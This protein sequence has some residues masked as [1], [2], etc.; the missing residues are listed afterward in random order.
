MV[1][2]SEMG[3][4]GGP[5]GE[6][7]SGSRP[8]GRNPTDLGNA[9]RLVARHGHN[10]RY[11]VADRE[12]RVWEGGLWRP[13]RTLEVIRLAK[14][15]VEAMHE[16]AEAAPT[17]EL[18]RELLAHGLASEASARIRAMVELAASEP[19]VVALP[20]QFDRDPW[21]LN[22]A[23]GTVDLRTGALRGHRREDL[24]TRIAPVRFDQGAEAP[25]WEA[26][27]S[28]ITEG[29]AGLVQ[30]LQRVAGYTLTGLTREHALFI[31]YGPGGNGKTTFVEALR[32]CLGGYAAQADFGSFLSGSRGIP[33]DIARLAG[34]RLVTAA[35]VDEGRRLDESRVKQLTGGD[36]VTARFLFRE[37]FEFDP[38][39]KLFLITNHRPEVRGTDHGLWRRIHLVPF[40]VT[41]PEE[42]IDSSL[43]EKLLEELPG[44][45]NWAVQ[46]CLAWQER[47]LDP[48]DEVRAATESYRREMDLAGTFIEDC[49]SVGEDR[50]IRA[51]D[52]YPAYLAWCR[53]VG[54]QPLSQKGLGARLTERGFHRARVGSPKAWRWEGIALA[55]PM[56]PFGPVGGGGR[57]GLTVTPDRTELA[58]MP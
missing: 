54:E 35:E 29:N 3:T 21:L 1:K 14:E 16:E 56:A 25:G 22:A 55:R 39:F 50:S 51:A 2:K 17:E 41:I 26:F 45:L 48:P 8:P 37:F 38:A 27:L 4:A 6:E 24:I 7:G 44:I 5:G 30:Y 20:E 53:S 47:G 10:L 52:L 43:R 13:D 46:G 11:V 15:T 34:C 57:G 23:N 31:L 58:R 9:R 19:E 28:R 36:R 40:D 49:C 32:A 18:R 33:N 12:W 42:E